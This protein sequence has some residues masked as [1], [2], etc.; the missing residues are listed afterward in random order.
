MVNRGG[1]DRGGEGAKTRTPGEGGAGRLGSLRG[2]RVSTFMA[3]ESG[4]YG[5]QTLLSPALL[6]VYAPVRL[7]RT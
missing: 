6:S 3:G 4:A 5:G 1:V 7:N 2:G